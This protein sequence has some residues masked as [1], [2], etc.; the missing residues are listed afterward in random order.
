M[1]TIHFKQLRISRTGRAVKRDGAMAASTK[2]IAGMQGT[3]VVV[4]DLRTH[5]TIIGT[6]ITAITGLTNTITGLANTITGLTSMITGLASVII[7]TPVEITSSATALTDVRI[8]F[9]DLAAGGANDGTF[10]TISTAFEGTK[11]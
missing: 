3:T 8:T 7:G 9:S 4:A 1:I 5:A 2:I 10:P 6:I 11:N